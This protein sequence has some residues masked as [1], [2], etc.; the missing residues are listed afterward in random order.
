[1]LTYLRNLGEPKADE[2]TDELI[3]EVDKNKDGVLSFE[4]L[5]GP[6]H[7]EL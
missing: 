1:M 6:G 2:I 3:K 7:D 4:E 5:L